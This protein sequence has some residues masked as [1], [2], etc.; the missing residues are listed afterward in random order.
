MPYYNSFTG[1]YL[2]FHF[3]SHYLL[4]AASCFDLLMIKCYQLWVKTQ[5]CL[6]RKIMYRFL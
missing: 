5:T 6:L 3:P 2:Q 4:L 1:K